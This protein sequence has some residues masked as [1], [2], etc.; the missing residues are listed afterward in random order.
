MSTITLQELIDEIAYLDGSLRDIYIFNKSLED[1]DRFLAVL[2]E[3]YSIKCEEEK[4][5]D[6]ILEIIP[7]VRERGFCITVEIGSG[8]YANCHFFVSIEE[9]TP[10]ELDLDP[11]EFN[12][13]E[14]VKCV[15]DFMSRLGDELGLDVFLTAENAP[16]I[17]LLEY[18]PMLKL[19]L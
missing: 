19:H 15:L 12:S 5:P 14:G 17:V 2:R 11:R 13:C 1:W 18:K 7:I 9:Q 16:D 8:I 6:S 3:K 4:I 10:I